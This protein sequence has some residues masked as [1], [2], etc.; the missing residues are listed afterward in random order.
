LFFLLQDF[1][2]IGFAYA[3]LIAA[4][5]KNIGYYLITR[6]VLQLTIGEL[7]NAYKLGIFSAIVTSIAIYATVIWLENLELP[8]LVILC[9]EIGVGVLSWLLSLYLSPDKTLLMQI[10]RKIDNAFAFKATSLP[11][12]QWLT[13]AKKE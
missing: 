1:G 9:A 8:Q 6:S 13:R 11:F 10:T 7:L 12:R 3:V 2:I 5:C 4:I